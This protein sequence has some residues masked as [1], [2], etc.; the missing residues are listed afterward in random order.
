MPF[1]TFSF[2]LESESDRGLSGEPGRQEWG[3]VP[4]LVSRAPKENTNPIMPPEKFS[5]GCHHGRLS[6][7]GKGS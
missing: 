3:F 5:F 4:R 7:G 2:S 1:S 6:S